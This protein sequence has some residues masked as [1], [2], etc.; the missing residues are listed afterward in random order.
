MQ[1]LKRAPASLKPLVIP[2]VTNATRNVGALANT[3]REIG[4]VTLGPSVQ[5]VDKEKLAKP[6]G[7]T[8]WVT[9]KQI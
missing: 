9:R 1:L 6:K 8:P 7:V 3:L 2:A 5:M 4:A